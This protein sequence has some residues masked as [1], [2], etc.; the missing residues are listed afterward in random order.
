MTDALVNHAMV[1][2]FIRVE[3]EVQCPVVSVEQIGAEP[4]EGRRSLAWEAYDGR[5]CFA[6][7]D[8][9]PAGVQRRSI[10]SA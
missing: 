3:V 6:V 1:D 10:G 7:L 8:G 9:R 2:S 4:D 5:R